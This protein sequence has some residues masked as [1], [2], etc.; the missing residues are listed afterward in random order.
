M[1][2]IQLISDLAEDETGEGIEDALEMLYEISE[3]INSGI[4]IE[5]LFFF[6]NGTGKLSYSL[7]GKVF[8]F[9]H[10]DKK[11][12]FYIQTKLKILILIK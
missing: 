7:M 1:Y 10:A 9:Q 12:Y 2:L 6:T 11:K 5:S 4:W 3:S 8:T